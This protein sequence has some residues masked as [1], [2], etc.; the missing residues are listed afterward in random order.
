[1]EWGVVDSGEGS[2]RMVFITG[3]GVGLGRRKFPGVGRKPLSDLWPLQLPSRFLIPDPSQRL[4]AG[5]RVGGC[6]WCPTSYFS[7]LARPTQSAQSRVGGGHL[8]SLLM[9]TV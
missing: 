1:M 2:S 3:A 4:F 8:A 6:K 9:G 5:R 7:R